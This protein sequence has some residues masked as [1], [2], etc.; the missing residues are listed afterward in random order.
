MS[1]FQGIQS[2]LG[3]LRK[4]HLGIALVLVALLIIWMLSG[5]FLRAQTEP[6]EQQEEPAAEAAYKVETKKLY[7]EA[8]SPMQIV[9]G[10]LEPLRTVEI[11][12]QI[13]AHLSKRTADWGARV[14]SGALLFQL[15]P[16]TRAAELERAQADLVVRE[17]ELRAGESL[18]KKDLLSET[19]YLRLKAAVASA[20]AERELNAL[21]L[22]YA[23]IHAPFD[24]I[25]DRLPVEEGDYVQVGQTL[26]TLV[27][28]SVLRLVAYVPQ[29]EIYALRPGF[30]VEARLLDGSSL[31]GTLTFVASLAE[32]STRSFRVE[33]RIDNPE[34]KRIAGSSATLSIRLPEQQAHH[35]SPAL[36]VL[37]DD[38]QLGIKAVDAQ[39]RVEFLSLKILSF[40]PQGVWVD[41]LPDD[42]EII[43]LGSGFVAAGDSVS[44]VEADDSVRAEQL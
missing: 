12:S 19:E 40:D 5:T 34:M 10:Q 8:Y 33:A 23:T 3:R 41:G 14:I 27:D 26:A 11:R 4:S 29:Q 6:P 42:V 16:E 25:V 38:G 2:S 36:L 39:Q 32:T 37:G 1:L 9:Q 31:Q 28:V 35:L 24:G 17:A 30:E 18:F 43:T 13:S 21:Q 7:A 15:D 44:P 20:K 22:N